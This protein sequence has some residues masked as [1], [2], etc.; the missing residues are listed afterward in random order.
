MYPSKRQSTPE[1]FDIQVQILVVDLIVNRI[2]CPFQ[3]L[4][5]VD[6]PCFPLHRSLQNHLPDVV[7]AVPV[8]TLK[9]EA[10]CRGPWTFFPTLHFPKILPLSSSLS[11]VE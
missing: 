4:Q 8:G 1:V 5:I 11:L 9:T 2:H 7:V 6:H 3:S 10:R